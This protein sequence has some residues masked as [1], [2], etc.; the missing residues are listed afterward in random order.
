MRRI[1]A[2]G[3]LMLLCCSQQGGEPGSAMSSAGIP[4]EDL[5]LRIHCPE[6]VDFGKAFSLQV[7]RIWRKDLSPDDWRDEQLAPLRLQL[8]RRERREDGERIEEWLHFDGY[9]FARAAVEIPAIAF[10]ARNSAGVAA[11][12]VQSEAITI[13]PS[14]GIDA[15][16]A[17]N[18]ELPNGPMRQPGSGNLLLTSGLAVLA[19]LSFVLWSSWRRSQGQS[20]GTQESRLSAKERATARIKALRPADPQDRQEIRAF[21][22]E[23]S[24]ALRAFLAEEHALPAPERTSEEVLA[25]LGSSNLLSAAKRELLDSF[26]D[27]C[28]RVK[29]AQGK[30]GQQAMVELLDAAESFLAEGDRA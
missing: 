1:A 29:F 26:L 25:S 10:S 12:Q 3:L 16:T 18:A 15:E 13:R 14:L 19:L 24:D 20:S 28:D 17:I 9:L 7:Q 21:H 4:Q 5:L 27:R 6:E 23:A 2:G 30:P 8:L 11:I 22:L